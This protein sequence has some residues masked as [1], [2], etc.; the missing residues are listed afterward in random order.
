M[1]TKLTLLFTLLALCCSAWGQK[2]V[3]LGSRITSASQLVSGRKYVLQYNKANAYPFIDDWETYYKVDENGVPPLETC[4]Y[5]LTSDGDNW[6][7]QSDYTLK[8]WPAGASERKLEP[9]AKAADAGSWSLTFD[10][11]GNAVAKSNGFGLDR[12]NG[13]LNTWHSDTNNSIRIYNVTIPTDDEIPVVISAYNGKKAGEYA[14]NTPTLTDYYYGNYSAVNG[15]ATFTTISTSGLTG[16]V[17]SNTASAN[18]FKPTYYSGTNYYHCFAIKPGNTT[19]YTVNITAP[20]GYYISGYSFN[21]ISTSSSYEFGLTIGGAAEKVIS[22]SIQTISGTNSTKTLS[23]DVQGKTSNGE[24]CF[25]ALTVV[26]KKK[27]YTVTYNV[28]DAQNN[29]LATKDVSVQEGTTV[30]SADIPT[31]LKRAYCT[32][33]F[34]SKTISANTV[35]NATYS[36][37]GAPFEFAT[38]KA[39]AIAN[40]KWY[41]LKL[42]NNNF[43]YNNSGALAY[44][45]TCL[46][47]DNFK[48]AIVGNPY[49]YKLL[50]KGADNYL[51][52]ELSTP[53]SKGYTIQYNFSFTNAGLDFGL[54]KNNSQGSATD[55]FTSVV[56]STYTN[57]VS[58]AAFNYY[59]T[60]MC[61][62]Y[63]KDYASGF[64]IDDGKLT[65]LGAAYMKPEKVTSY[66]FALNS[67]G[68]GTPT[69]YATLYL[70]FDATISG[71]DAFTLDKSGKYLVPTEVTGNEVPAGTPVLLKGTSATATATINSG[72][73]F[74]S[75]TPL[76]CALTGTYVDLPVE[77]TDGISNDYYLG[78]KDSKVGFY[79]WS[80][81]T[82]KANRAYLTAAN[83][84][85]V[86]EF[87]LIFE[88]DDATGIT[89]PIGESQEKVSIYNMAGQ[90]VSKA[91]KG[92]YIVNGKKVLF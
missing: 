10:G 79:K 4:V 23:F 8:Y 15:A 74:N 67:D 17:V 47:N 57:T 33:S 76:S 66:S 82:L 30:T 65:G 31:F 46:D 92:I 90:R 84:S 20:T 72:A 21:V 18:I 11:N 37:A 42:S 54:F 9:V 53:S 44:N 12:S 1:K 51:Y 39:D 62:S 3:I 41:T 29:V 52:A 13:Q 63:Y 27:Y 61:I 55:Y 26:L 7:I 6:K 28:V 35:I 91:Q 22:S 2:N 68:A 64:T 78:I 24:L 69:Y 5:I 70:P 34:A 58:G 73:A 36:F 50:N 80:G 45:A 25:P 59:G 40:F 71:A 75:G 81:T 88:E 77:K 87:Q 85:Q 56:A 32:Y 89:S 83:A 49:S 60:S 14:S 86:K 19:K 48:W 16:V 43:I 38:S